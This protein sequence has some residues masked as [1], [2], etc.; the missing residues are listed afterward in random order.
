SW[1]RR[2]CVSG[3]VGLGIISMAPPAFA[4]LG[5]SQ[6]GEAGVAQ[7]G[8]GSAWVATAD[9]PIAVYYNPAALA[10]QRT[11]LHG[12]AD[13]MSLDRSFARVNED[14]SFVSPGQGLPAAGAPGGP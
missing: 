1:R 8:L 2:S 3:L 9:D 13:F 11:S 5:Q 6:G 10:R 12:G 14:G 7:I 4:Q